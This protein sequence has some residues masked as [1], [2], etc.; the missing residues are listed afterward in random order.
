MF[1]NIYLT[2]L[3]RVN[4]KLTN[5]LNRHFKQ[6]KPDMLKVR[7]EPFKP[8]IHS[9]KVSRFGSVQT[10]PLP[11]AI[12]MVVS[13]CCE[14]LFSF[15]FHTSAHFGPNFQPNHLTT[16]TFDFFTPIYVT[17]TPYRC[18]FFFGGFKGLPFWQH[19][20][21][22]G[23]FSHEVFSHSMYKYA[24]EMLL[25]WHGFNLDSDALWG[26][27]IVVSILDLWNS[28]RNPNECMSNH[29]HEPIC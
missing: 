6:L 15:C 20:G 22:F 12:N 1:K 7:A 27:A 17:I 28:I 14:N 16:T 8:L 26:H 10:K 13:M 11:I 19:I 5:C 23:I 21:M 25:S 9:V 4:P 24:C 2:K 29:F 18:L 3:S